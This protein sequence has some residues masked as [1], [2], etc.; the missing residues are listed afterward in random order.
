MAVEHFCTVNS[1]TVFQLVQHIRIVLLGLDAAEGAGV[2]VPEIHCGEES[3]IYLAYLNDLF[4]RAQLIYLAH[5][6]GAADD[7]AQSL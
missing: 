3:I 6:L 2:Q 1:Q 5:G 7:V 4:Q